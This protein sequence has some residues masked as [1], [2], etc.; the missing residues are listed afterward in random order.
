MLPERQNLR[1]IEIDIARL[2]Y[3]PL[4]R[5]PRR[6]E[7]RQ[8]IE[9]P[10]PLG[11][12][13]HFRTLEADWL[14]GPVETIPKNERP[15]PAF[16]EL[17]PA[18]SG[19]IAIDDLGNAE[20]LGEI[21]AAAL[22]YDR[23][24]RLVAKRGLPHGIYRVEVNPLGRGMIA[25]A[26]SCIVHAYREDLTQIFEE[27]LKNTTEIAAL[28]QRFQIADD[29]LKNHIRCVAL[30]QDMKA[31]L[32]T[33]VDQAW[34]VGVDGSASWAVK[35]PLM[36]G[37]KRVVRPSGS[38][39][40]SAEVR[41]ALELMNLSLP[42]TSDEFKHRYRE[43]AKWWH[44]DVNRDGSDGGTKMQELN[45]AAEVLTGIAASDLPHYAEVEFIREEDQV[46][47]T[48]DGISITMN[49]VSGEITASDWIY[50]ASFAAQSGAA[51]VAG[52]SG[53][54]ILLDSM[55]NGVRVYDIGS[56][57]RRIV[58]TGDYLYL[59]TDT[60]LYVLRENALHALVD[61]AEAGDII[62]TETGFGLLEKNC[63][64]WFS[65]DGRYLGGVQASTPIRRV[66]SAENGVVVET[67]QHRTKISGMPVWWH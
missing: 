30:A 53:R 66:Y 60:R 40:T 27:N 56:V 31:Y 1:P 65:E 29:Q 28:R 39:N 41:R 58:D 3:V 50:A 17:Y 23:G 7:R 62:V 46:S 54:V 47:V 13:E 26:P 51:Y 9:S 25:M 20:G 8:Q 37:W 14:L 43:L 35:L 57:P 19:V 55:G 45:A 36:A 64:R 12:R 11:R 34:C 21:E 42:L 33:A 24:G 4:P 6:W 16:R 2:E 5:A 22:R 38:F 15:D 44:P 49:T 48:I 18:S 61:T 59:L 67:R 63:L 52:Y 10:E 32:F